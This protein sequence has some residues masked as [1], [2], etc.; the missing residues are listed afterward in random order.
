M[1]DAF[2]DIASTITG[3]DF[4]AEGRTAQQLGLAGK[5]KEEIYEMN[6]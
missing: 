4:R 1:M 3:R 5:T 6:S 2:I